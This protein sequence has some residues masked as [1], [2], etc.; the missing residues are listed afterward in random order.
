MIR[1]KMRKPKAS[2]LISEFESRRVNRERWSTT[3]PR[4]Y[5]FPTES[6]VTIGNIRT[7]KDTITD[8]MAKQVLAIKN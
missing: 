6:I 5:S 4:S 8:V 2:K 7:L 3:C 1:Q